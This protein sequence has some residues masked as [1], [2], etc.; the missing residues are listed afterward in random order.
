MP[1]IDKHASRV[2][3]D[4]IRDILNKQWDPIGGCPADEYD[5]YVG[6]IAAMIRDDATDD[7]LIEY[8]RWAEAV[9]MGSGRFDAERGHKVIASLR[10]LEHP[11]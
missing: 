1:P 6:K 2:W 5:R 11:R 7:E 10:A 3:R 9:H 4:H 8:L